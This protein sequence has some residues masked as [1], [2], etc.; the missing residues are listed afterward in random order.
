MPYVLPI[1]DAITQIHQAIWTALTGYPAWNSFVSKGSR[2]NFIP[3]ASP[4][5][6]NSEIANTPVALKTAAIEPGDTPEVRISQRLYRRDPTN[7]NSMAWSYRQDFLIQMSTTSSVLDLT[8]QNQ[9]KFLTELALRKSNMNLGLPG[10]VR[11]WDWFDGNDLPMDKES[12]LRM[13][14]TAY[15]I[16]VFFFLTKSA[17]NAM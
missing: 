14:V 10:L 6:S 16:S 8:P 17:I 2:V 13:W 3:G 4:G 7:D 12:G 11:K 1:T 15:G 5:Y 9:I